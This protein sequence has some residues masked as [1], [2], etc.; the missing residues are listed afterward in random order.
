MRPTLVVAL[1]LL[2]ALAGA[3]GVLFAVESAAG[4]RW[5]PGF[6]RE[7]LVRASP[8]TTVVVSKPVLANGSTEEDLRRARRRGRD[9]LFVFRGK[10]AARRARKAPGSSS[11]ARARAY[12][13]ARDRLERRHPALCG[14]RASGL[15]AVHDGDRVAAQIVGWDP[16]DD[17]G[18]LRVSPSAHPLVPVPL[19]SSAALRSASRSRRSALRS[20]LGLALGRGGLGHRPDDPVARRPPTTS[21]TRSRPTRRSTRATRAAR[22]SMRRVT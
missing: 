11:T 10:P 14:A 18:V 9:G 7:P 16:Y 5:H 20:A 12:G 21:S 8:P 6:V 1:C 3:G 19:G 13:C 22:C 17:V 4:R 15:R 2:A